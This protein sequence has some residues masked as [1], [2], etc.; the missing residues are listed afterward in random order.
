[1]DACERD[2]HQWIAQCA[3]LE[4]AR[5]ELARAA[6]DR[7]APRRASQREDALVACALAAAPHEDARGAQLEAAEAPDLHLERALEAADA[8]GLAVGLW[9]GHPDEL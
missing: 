1:V 7:E 2:R 5:L 4:G 3:Y 8:G 6:R 9:L